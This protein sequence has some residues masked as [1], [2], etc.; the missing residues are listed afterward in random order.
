M[1]FTAITRE[2]LSDPRVKDSAFLT[3][4]CT[5]TIAI[6]P[7]QQP[8]LPW[9][10]YLAESEGVFVGA[11]AFKSLPQNSEVEIAYFTFPECEG[12][13][14]AT[15]MAE[16]LIEIANQNGIHRVTAQTLPEKNASTHILEKL[17]FI[18]VGVVDHPEDGKVWEWHL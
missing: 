16:W 6:Y 5:S 14:V 2:L 17:K 4:V 13:G 7:D 3:Q 8:I 12:K 11:C 1:N 15:H 10:G 9:V 18:F